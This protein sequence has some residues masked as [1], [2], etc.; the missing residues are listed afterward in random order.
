MITNIVI[1]EDDLKTR[2]RLERIIVKADELFC[3]GSFESAELLIKKFKHL[4]VNIVL[5]DIDLGILN[6]NGIEAV[7]RLKEID[8]SVE[9]IMCT[10]YSDE[11]KI[12]AAANR[13][14]T[15]Y[16]IKSD[17]DDEILAS[18]RD[19]IKGGAPM[20]PQI[21]KKVFKLIGEKQKID[22]SILDILRDRELEAMDWIRKGNNQKM[23]ADK[24]GISHSTVKGYCKRVYK[25]LNVHSITEA[26]KKL[27]GEN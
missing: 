3:C 23:T 8:E 13:G 1:V 27:Y 15:G 11:D 4:Y 6:I 9:I 12:I 26:L 21:A 20:S 24:M 25:A 5:M 22:P 14:A 2:E 7:G 10:S 19:A 16:L 17:K 18:I